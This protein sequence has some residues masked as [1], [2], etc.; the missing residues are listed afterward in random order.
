MIDP[1]ALLNHDCASEITFGALKLFRTLL[2][3]QDKTI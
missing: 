2:P 1:L 3:E